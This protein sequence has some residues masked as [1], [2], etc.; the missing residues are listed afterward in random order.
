PPAAPV[1]CGVSL[2]HTAAPRNAQDAWT[3]CGLTFTCCV[4]AQ[5]ATNADAASATDMKRTQGWPSILREPGVMVVSSVVA[6]VPPGCRS[7]RATW[8]T[9]GEWPVAP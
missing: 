4:V 6:S 2:A 9:R 8:R 1:F 3:L 5:P 7:T